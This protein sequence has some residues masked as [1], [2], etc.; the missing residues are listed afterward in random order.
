MNTR[1]HCMA[2]D[3]VPLLKTG[4]SDSEIGRRLFLNRHAVAV[5]RH[6]LHL[7]PAKPVGGPEPLETKFIRHTR[8]APGGHLQ[9]IG[10]RTQDLVPVLSHGPRRLTA[11]R[12]AYVLE[13]GREPVGRVRP[14]CGF[15]WCVAPGDQADRIDLD[16]QRSQ[17]RQLDAASALLGAN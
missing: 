12:V 5:V 8:S 17:A 14:T 10:P 2:A 7:P 1:P 4:L 9:W 3:I 16:L 6:D 13:H 15:H 11:R